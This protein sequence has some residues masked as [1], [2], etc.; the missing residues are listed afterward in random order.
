[1]VELKQTAQLKNLILQIEIQKG[2][3][4]IKFSPTT[5]Q[6]IVYCQSKQHLCTA[7]IFDY[8]SHAFP[9]HFLK[10]RMVVCDIILFCEYCHFD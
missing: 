9:L 10:V 2:A 4:Q 5:E 7:I 8:V 6:L 3:R 1:M